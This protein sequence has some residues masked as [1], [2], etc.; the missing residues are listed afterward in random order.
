MFNLRTSAPVEPVASNED[1]YSHHQANDSQS[2]WTEISI[3][4]GGRNTTRSTCDS[5]E[6]PIGGRVI[7]EVSINVFIVVVI[8]VV[9]I[10]VAGVVVASVVIAAVARGTPFSLS[11]VKR[12]V[13]VHV[14]Q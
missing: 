7:L 14:V 2:K 6:E 4:V 3:P 11:I 5:G 10:V 1:N 9:V 12:K 8:V 13:V